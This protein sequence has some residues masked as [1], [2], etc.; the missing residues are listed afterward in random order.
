VAAAITYTSPLHKLVLAGTD[1][2]GDSTAYDKRSRVEAVWAVAHEL[3]AEK[4]GDDRVPDWFTD[5][6]GNALMAQL[7]NAP[8][9][10]SVETLMGLVK[11]HLKIEEKAADGP[12]PHAE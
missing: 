10:V 12:P 11:D 9:D 6:K 7:Q 5:V 1:A 4:Y 2:K 8:D 3:A